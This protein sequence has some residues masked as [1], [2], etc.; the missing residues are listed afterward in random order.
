[1]RLR[2]CN[3]A[4]QPSEDVS[5]SSTGRFPKW[6]TSIKLAPGPYWD[7]K[8]FKYNLTLGFCVNFLS[9]VVFQP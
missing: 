5:I 2:N 3:R 9:L 7:P 8:I 6:H 4:I 1:M